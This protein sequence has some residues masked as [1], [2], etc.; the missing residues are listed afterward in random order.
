M[1]K[2]SRALLVLVLIIF[3][4]LGLNASNQGINQLTMENRESVI[5]LNLEPETPGMLIMGEK[6]DLQRDKIISCVSP[7]WQKGK[8]IF[9]RCQEH[10]S[11]IWRIFKAVFLS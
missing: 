5:G 7:W 8:D 9:V 2:I 6:Y 3:V 10:F 1:G 11:K 4:G